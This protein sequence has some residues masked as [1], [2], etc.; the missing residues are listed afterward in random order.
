MK[1]SKNYI[2][3][4]LAG[5]LVLSF[6]TVTSEGATS[7]PKQYDAVLLTE[8][9]ACLNSLDYEQFRFAGRQ[10]REACMWW[11]PPRYLKAPASPISVP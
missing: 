9:S 7:T 11:Y 1:N 3:A 10:A 8:Y 4:I 2:I 5:L 6:S